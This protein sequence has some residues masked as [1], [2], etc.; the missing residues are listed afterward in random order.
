MMSGYRW[1]SSLVTTYQMYLISG[2]KLVYPFIL[3]FHI[4]FKLKI[5]NFSIFQNFQNY[6]QKI[7]AKF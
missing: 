6:C 4:W 2:A 3:S 5:F 1:E 7:F